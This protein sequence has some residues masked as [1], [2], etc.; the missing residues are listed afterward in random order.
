MERGRQGARATLSR[1]S[2]ADGLA[3]TGNCA[4]NDAAEAPSKRSAAKGEGR[5]LGAQRAASAS[6]DWRAVSRESLGHLPH[7][8]A[9]EAV[10]GAG[11]VGI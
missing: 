5:V 3:S 7:G 6:A 10:S 9:G 11:P 4:R 1:P 2:R 8:C